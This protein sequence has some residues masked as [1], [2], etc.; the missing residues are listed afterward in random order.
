MLFSTASAT[1]TITGGFAAGFSFLPEHAPSARSR[2][3]SKIGFRLNPSV[4]PCVNPSFKVGALLAAPRLG[5]A[6]AAPTLLSY[7]DMF[8]C[9]RN[10]NLQPS[11]CNPVASYLFF[12]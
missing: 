9:R 4:H 1:V 6:S 12:S 11:A 3:N 7:L 5:G 2:I 10:I 8:N